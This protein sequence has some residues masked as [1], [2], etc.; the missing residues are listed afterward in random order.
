M[1]DEHAENEIEV[2]DKRDNETIGY[3]ENTPRML[4][5]V[6]YET[7]YVDYNDQLININN[8]TN[9]NLIIIIVIIAIIL[10]L[11]IGIISYFVLFKKNQSEIENEVNN[12]S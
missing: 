1:K 2:T 8:K 9:T 3:V 6:S 7:G 4:N 11:I 12:I 5:T 10:I